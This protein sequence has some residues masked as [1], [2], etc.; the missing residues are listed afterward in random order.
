MTPSLNKRWKQIFSQLVI[1]DDILFRI[2]NHIH[3]DLPVKC[4][5]IPESIQTKI[6]EQH[7]D[8]PVCGHLGLEK[9]LACL[10]RNVY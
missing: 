9:S 1:E 10:E 3:L 5:V 7:H 8:P 6:I 4:R 2:S